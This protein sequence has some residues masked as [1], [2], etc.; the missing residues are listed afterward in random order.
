MNI[1]H[2]TVAVI[3]SALALFGAAAPANAEPA[4]EHAICSTLDQHP[5]ISGVTA[6][7]ASLLSE[8]MTAKKAGE[9][10][11]VSTLLGCDRHLELV[12]EWADLAAANQLP[13]QRMQYS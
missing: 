8:G 5:T 10:V 12:S 3:G 11:M 13:V 9:T 4:W 1:K 7:V 6:V 2:I